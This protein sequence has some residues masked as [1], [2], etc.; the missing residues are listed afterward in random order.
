MVQLVQLDRITDDKYI[1]RWEVK[2]VAL[3]FE[4][5]SHG[6]LRHNYATLRYRSLKKKTRQRDGKRKKHGKAEIFI[7][8]WFEIEMISRGNGQNSLD[9]SAMIGL[10]LNLVGLLESSSNYFIWYISFFH[11]NWHDWSWTQ[12]VV[13]VV[14]V[15]VSWLSILQLAASFPNGIQFQRRITIELPSLLWPTFVS[16]NEKKKLK[17]NNR[18]QQEWCMR[19]AINSISTGE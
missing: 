13:V 10:R 1:G 11:G 14:V 7:C 15:V 6:F 2:M 8:N 5:V 9:E 3:R 16:K 19:L 17:N 4:S 12:N 18:N